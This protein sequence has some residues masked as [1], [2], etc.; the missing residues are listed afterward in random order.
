MLIIAFLSPIAVGSKVTEKYRELLDGIT[1]GSETDTEFK[2]K[3]LTK[4]SVGF[5]HKISILFIVNGAPP[6]FSI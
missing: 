6:K 2:T 4:K 1:T 3:S 5:N